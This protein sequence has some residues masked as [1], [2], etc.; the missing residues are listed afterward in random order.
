[1][2]SVHVIT[3]PAA[4]SAWSEAARARGERIAFVPTMGALHAGHV[5]L[6]A[7]ARKQGDRV[8]LSIF[9]N[10]TQFGPQEDLARYPRDLEGDLS[11]AAS[12]GTD[13]AFVPSVADM[14]PPGAQTFIDVRE[15]AQGLCGERR[16]G[17]FTGVATVV[18]KLF[19]I[20][21]PNVALLG[22]KDFQQLA[23]IR[24]MVADLNMPVE[25]VGRPTLRESDGLAM[26]SRNAYLSPA[27]RG[28]AVAIFRG[29]S[30]ARERF[31]AGERGAI[32]L[33]ESALS[34]MKDRVDRIDYVEI[35]DAESLRPVERL[36][37]PAVILA[38]AF[39]GATRLID[40]MRLG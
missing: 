38:A 19:G 22:E 13:V 6:L 1:M 25:I 39:V 32:A 18:A 20:V 10:P 35:R 24:R 40:N 12:V 7:A 16:P 9:V 15:V 23:V 14:Y 36:E 2:S 8:V 30:A 11:Q 37:K 29:V 33:V 26:S 21:R 34:A 27:E 5:S 3:T 17:H 4:M 28:R 31:A